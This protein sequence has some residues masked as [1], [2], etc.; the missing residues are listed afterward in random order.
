MTEKLL[1]ELST[2]QLLDLAVIAIDEITALRKNPGHEELAE[3]KR[4]DLFMI[5][6]ELALRDETGKL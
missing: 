1:K 3:E 2:Q 5:N 4:S 6:R